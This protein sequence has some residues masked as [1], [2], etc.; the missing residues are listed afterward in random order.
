MI[1]SE[2]ECSMESKND[3]NFFNPHLHKFSGKRSVL[4][5]IIHPNY[6]ISKLDPQRTSYNYVSTS[7]FQSSF[8]TLFSFIYQP[9]LFRHRHFDIRAPMLTNLFIY[10]LSRSRSRAY[11]SGRPRAMNLIVSRFIEIK[12]WL[13]V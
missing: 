11:C 6:P 3:K 10:F 13:K 9:L 1:G 5:E 2:T 4:N 8:P 12:I 7:S